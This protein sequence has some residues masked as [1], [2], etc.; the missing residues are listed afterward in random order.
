MEAINGKIQIALKKSV[1]GCLGIYIEDILDL[2]EMFEDTISNKFMQSFMRI[3]KKDV[4]DVPLN[5]DS[6][7]F[8]KDDSD[9]DDSDMDD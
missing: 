1:I 7:C 6:I 2:S 4:Y 5:I 3:V 8:R 9:V